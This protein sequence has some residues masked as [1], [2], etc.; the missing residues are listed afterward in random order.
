M[1]QQQQH[2]ILCKTTVHESVT[3]KYITP[4]RNINARNNTNNKNSIQTELPKMI[5]VIVTDPDATDT[6]SSSDEESQFIIPRRRIKQ[7][8]NKIEIETVVSTDS[9]NKKLFK[10]N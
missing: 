7:Y 4:K 6:D 3:K 8:V 10:N 2:S 5:R 1:K 9:R